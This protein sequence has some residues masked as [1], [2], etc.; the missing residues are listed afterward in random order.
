MAIFPTPKQPIIFVW[1]KKIC[2]QR[3]DVGTSM[4][5]IGSESS[6]SSGVEK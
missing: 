4:L 6:R 5:Y 1:N 3:R 2:I